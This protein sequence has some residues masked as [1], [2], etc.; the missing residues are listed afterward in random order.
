MSR[1]E[2]G[3]MAA[4]G[5]DTGRMESRRDFIRSLSFGAA[6]LALHGGARPAGEDGSDDGGGGRRPN[7]LFCIADDWSW[8]HASIAGDRVV[9]TP[10][11]D[12]A[13]REG[14][15]FPRA[16][17]SSPSCTPSRGAILTGQWHWRL[18]EGANLWSTL[19]ARFDVFP[20]LLE[21]AGY[22]VGF[23]RKGWGPGSVEAGGRGR[24]AAGV[25]YKNF[26]QFM[27][28]RPE[29]APFCFWFGSHDPHRGYKKGSGIASGMDPADVA[30]PACLPDCEEV[31]SDICDYFFEVQRFDREVGALMAAL[32]ERG[33]LDDTIVAITSD[34]GMPFPRCKTNLYDLGANVPLAVRWGR[35]VPGGRVVDDLVSL[36]DMA[37]TF[38]EAAG[39]AVPAEM[40]GRSLV[41]VLLAEGSG[42][43]DPARDRTF[44]GRER[45]TVAQAAGPGGYPMRA[46][47]TENFLYIR[48]FE[49]GRWPAGAPGEYLDIDGSPTKTVMLE[50]REEAD[51]KR[52]FELACGKRPAEE[53]Y[54]LRKDPGQLIDV[55]GL[56]EYADALKKL[57]RSLMD[58]LERT[59]DPRISGRGEVFD[60]YAYQGRT[61]KYKPYEG[62][63]RPAHW[64]EPL[65][66][67]D[68]LPNLYRVDAQIFR[69]AQPDDE[70]FTELKRMG[71][72]T[73]VN[74]RSV[75][76]DRRECAAAGLDYVKITAQAWEA[77]EEEVVEFL[78]LAVDPIRL[79][80]FVHCQH[81]ADRTGLM[82]AAY[83]VAVQGWS[84]E[85]AISEMTKGGFGHHTIWKG[86]VEYLRGFDIDDLRKKAGI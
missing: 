21:R 54:D 5:M 3:S 30:V 46:V 66:D 17:V 81:G 41:S 27:E 51:V 37:P 74:L 33:E 63:A 35:R 40:T 69:G 58:E 18:E 28:A 2:E 39:V 44:F 29:G 68:G 22:H 67:V 79:P 32:E 7:I 12:R 82:C 4:K 56:P 13:A 78:K 61:R 42:R 25:R 11:F 19:P 57:A 16:F 31:R 62:G 65:A 83:R 77:E 1:I 70:G 14:V 84:R 59:G 24:N 71:I 20:D 38:L 45:H 34:N 8:P 6:A 23:T 72:K 85:E 73:V 86:L 48:N 53:L 36:T 49:P 76:S 55:A 43:V 15:L 10:A 52:L 9:M 26:E 64:A 47:R 75:H 60:N 50:R 80:I